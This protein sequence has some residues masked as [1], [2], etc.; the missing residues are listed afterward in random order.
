LDGDV[1]FFKPLFVV[2][3]K[4]GYGRG[5]KFVVTTEL[6]SPK[7]TGG[8]YWTQTPIRKKGFYDGAAK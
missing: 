8:N 3:L 6:L 5:K 1:E 2:W 7:G 4:T